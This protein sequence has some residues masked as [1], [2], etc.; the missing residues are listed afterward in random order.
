MA[1]TCG[2]CLLY[3]G[4]NQKCGGGRQLAANTSAIST[5]FKGPA[6][7][8]SRKEC[9]GCRLYQGP[10]QKC[11]GGRQLVANTSAISSCYSP[12]PG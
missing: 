12:N 7:L 10:N 4:P 3:Q 2:A 8:F 5:C 11:G 1:N 9:G 6:S